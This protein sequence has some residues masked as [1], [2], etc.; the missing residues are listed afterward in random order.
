RGLGGRRGGFLRLLLLR[1]TSLELGR[2]D[3]DLLL[4]HAALLLFRDEGHALLGAL[5]RELAL[6]LFDA[7]GRVDVALLTRE[8]GVAFAAD[9][10]LEL[11]DGRA[12]LERVPARA[13]D[14]ALDILRVDSCLHGISSF[15]GTR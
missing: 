7:A 10:Q 8:E 6:E 13:S 12:R 4:L 9:I 15:F 14:R 1:G 3:G 2:S 11:R 5:L